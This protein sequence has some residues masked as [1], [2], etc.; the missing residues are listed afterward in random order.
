MKRIIIVLT[1]ILIVLMNENVY[2]IKADTNYAR[3]NKTTE[4][5]KTFSDNNSLE[6][7]LCLAEVTYYV[8]IISDYDTLYKINYNGIVGYIKKTDVKKIQNTPITP[9]PYNIKLTIN[10]NC[11]LRSTPTTK[12][13]SNNTIS[14]VYTTSEDIVFIGRA[15]GEEAIDFGGNTWYYVCYNG[16]YGYIYNNYVKS[17]TPIYKNSE[18]YEYI[19]E[20]TSSINNPITHTPSLIIIIFLSIPLFLVII[21][22]YLPH[23][24]K[25][26]KSKKQKII[27]EIERY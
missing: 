8:E 4:I 24:N 10:S 21:I 7:I 13:S 23:K 15:I 12:S 16:D 3:I 19:N 9:Y 20:T 27:R 17:I 6:N 1:L 11:N 18:K 5:Y 22:L 25:P 26:T 14:I 2:T